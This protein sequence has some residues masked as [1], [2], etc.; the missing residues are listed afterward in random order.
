M[1]LQVADGGVDFQIWRVGAS[2]LNKQSYVSA[3]VWYSSF[4]FGRGDRDSLLKNIRLG[5]EQST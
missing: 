4:G 3:K 5:T 2:M 1:C